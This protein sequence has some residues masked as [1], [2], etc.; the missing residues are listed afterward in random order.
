VD[1]TTWS[2][3][4]LAAILEMAGVQA[5]AQRVV[6]RSADGYVTGLTLGEALAA[7]NFLAYEWMGQPVPVLHGFPVRAVLPGVTGSKWV[8]WLLEIVV[9]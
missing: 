4:P 6:M 8:K 5:D 3:A 2:G 7:E 1:T 9:E